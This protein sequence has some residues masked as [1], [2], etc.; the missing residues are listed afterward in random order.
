[1]ITTNEFACI[2]HLHNRRFG[3]GWWGE[4]Y[5][6]SLI[7][8]SVADRLSHH[9][10]ETYLGAS[11]FSFVRLAR[12][13]P[14]AAHLGCCVAGPACCAAAL[15]F[16]FVTLFRPV[17]ESPTT[18]IMSDRRASQ[19]LSE[20]V[21]NNQW[22]QNPLLGV[23]FGVLCE[24]FCGRTCTFTQLLLINHKHRVVDRSLRNEGASLLMNF[25][26]NLNSRFTSVIDSVGPL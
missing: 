13:S 8:H 22:A 16:S 2:S 20:R 11:L 19:L 15:P 25:L 12:A 14:G 6:T 26:K 21:R 9:T 5:S 4:G 10:N 7:A 18:F 17:P 23:L 24:F 3:E 1:M